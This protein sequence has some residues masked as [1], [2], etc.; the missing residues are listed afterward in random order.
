M[1]NKDD[2]IHFQD[3][4]EE[5]TIINGYINKI[6]KQGE[7]S[8]Y[9]KIHNVSYDLAENNIEE[10]EEPCTLDEIVTRFA[11]EALNLNRVK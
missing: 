3:W 6:T 11:Y 9:M 2:L 10:T 4:L 8:V 7:A 1:D 5:N